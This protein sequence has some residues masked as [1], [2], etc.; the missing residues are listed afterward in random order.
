M[1]REIK[2]RAWS[3]TSEKMIYRVIVGNTTTDDP[4]SSVWDEDNKEWVHFD[5]HCGKI[6]QF[7][8]LKD[9]NEIPIY[10]GDIVRILYS[11]WF[12]KGAEDTRSIE[13]YKKD[14]ASIKVVVYD[15][16]GFYLS[17]EVGGY[18]ETID[19]GRHGFIEVI[20]NIYQ[21]PEL[22]ERKI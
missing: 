2:F 15:F 6:M 22:L 20:G 4:C 8:G 19:I 9:K 7:T 21:N 18:S 11:E 17:N 12:S 3:K 1:N 16:N 14:I 13:Q 5:K 10:E